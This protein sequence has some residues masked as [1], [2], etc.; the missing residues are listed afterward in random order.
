VKAFDAK[1]ATRDGL[2][3]AELPGVT[4]VFSTASHP[5][6]ATAGRVLDHVT[7]EVRGLPEFCERLQAAG[8]K[9]DRPYMKQKTMDLGVAFLTDPWG[10]SLELTEGYDKIGR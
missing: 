10:T 5:V 1:R 6:V 3:A 2:P 4:L 7:F 8:F 9:L